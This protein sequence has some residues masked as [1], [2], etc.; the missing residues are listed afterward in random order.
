[1]VL[2]RPERNRDVRAEQRCERGKWRD[3]DE[4]G[5][6]ETRAPQLAEQ[7]LDPKD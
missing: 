2:H 1:V 3:R 5:L 4:G 7:S 6:A